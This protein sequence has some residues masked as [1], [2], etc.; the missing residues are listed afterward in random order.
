MNAIAKGKLGRLL[1]KKNISV[2]SSQHNPATCNRKEQSNV[3]D[4]HNQLDPNNQASFGKSL[5]MDEQ[6][7]ASDSEASSVGDHLVDPN[8]INLDESFF[9]PTFENQFPIARDNVDDPWQEDT[10]QSDSECEEPTGEDDRMYQILSQISEYD[11]IANECSESF[12]RRR[13][14]MDLPQQLP[15]DDYDEPF[16]LTQAECFPEN[17]SA[18]NDPDWECV[19]AEQHAHAKEMK[20]VEIFVSTSSSQKPK[21]LLDPAEKLKRQEW[22]NTKK[23]YLATHKTHLLLLLAYGIRINRT[24]NHNMVEFASELYDLIANSE[25]TATDAT[26]LEFIESVVA[27][28]KTVMKQSTAGGGPRMGKQRNAFVR[29]LVARE[30]TSR[31]MLNVIL[32]TL[33]RFLSVRARFVMS[34]DVVPKYPPSVK[35]TPKTQWQ[36]PP[37]GNVNSASGT[38]RYGDV[39]LTTTEILKRKPEIQ[40]MFQLSQLDG[41]D[42]ELL[43]ERKDSSSPKPQLWSLKP[44]SNGG[45]N[46]P[47]MGE[48]MELDLTTKPNAVKMATSNYFSKKVALSQA[49]I[50][51]KNTTNRKPNFAN[52]RKN[53]IES[54]SKTD[55]EVE[56]KRLKLVSCK[57]FR[58]KPKVGQTFG[59]REHKST[60]TKDK[61]NLAKLLKNK[62]ESASGVNT[63]RP[64]PKYSVPE[65]DTWIECYLEQEQRWTVVEAG[66]GQTDCLDSVID[67]ILAPAAYV[68]AWEADGT[69][70]DV[71]SRYRWRNEQLA[72]RNRVDGK[73]LL[74][75]LA[76][77]RFRGVDEARLREQLEFRRLKLR[78]PMPTTIAQCKNHPSYCLH[79]HLQKFQGIYPPDAP[80]LGYIQGEPLYARECVH[81]LHSRE[82]WLRHAKVIRLFEQPY[83]IVRTKLKRQPA[84]LELF[85]YWQTEDYIPPEPVNGIVPRNAYG[86]I[87]IFKEC[88]LPKGTVHLK[89]YGLSYVCRK[90]GIDYA[91]AVVGFG[92]H[93][94]GNHPVFDGIVIC[95]EHRDR[96]LEAW[97][98]HQDE[99]AQKKL[100]KKQNA[101]LNNWVKLVKGLLVRKKLKH[102]YNFEGW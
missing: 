5:P 96:L 8:T 10:E 58:K 102:K 21:R 33:L 100:E 73:W 37:K 83:K 28:Y 68:F 61:P 14:Q 46:D 15:T 67:R 85:G 18:G 70:V 50:E 60:T 81:T 1:L 34:L 93:A 24:V 91:V 23:L 38:Q 88:M 80:P 41:A 52:L 74:K 32:L 54:S 57:Y 44:S 2:V 30:V 29:Q 51:N 77:Y 66:L 26:S 35:S 76:S 12:E 89:Q 86:N 87:E 97:K 65:L 3:S 11:R 17:P 19:A 84:D 6:D 78:A 36:N 92:V 49:T 64:D 71:S 45:I 47:K 95:E 101:V 63:K 99:V 39:P 4:V 82:V 69:I 56:E 42:D 43:L 72:L 27:Y 25:L 59:S 7:P 79:R 48:T 31:K 98:R 20:N 55:G 13:K 75:A 9:S 40:Q 90:L 53:G 22:E 94:G 16:L 62:P